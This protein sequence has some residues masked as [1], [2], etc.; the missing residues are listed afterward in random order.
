[1][2]RL[3]ALLALIALSAAVP[4]A[5]EPLL[6]PRADG[7]YSNAL[8]QQ[9]DIAVYLPE[10]SADEPASRYE[11]LYVLDGDWNA[12]IVT[13]IVSFMRQ[14]G[15]LPPLIVVSVPNHFDADGTNSRDHD[16]T[17]TASTDQA[18]S[19][20]AASFLAFLKT[21]LVP[22]VDAHYPANGIRSIH[23]HSYGGLFLFYVLMNDPSLFDGYIVLDPAMG[24]DKHLFDKIV[25]A[26]LPSVPG[27]GKAFYVATR[28]G[29]AYERMGMAGLEPIFRKRAPADFHWKVRG[30]PGETHDSLKLK[31][32]YDA[33]KFVFDG[34]TQDEIDF[35]P[36]G[37]TLIEGR[38]LA[39][40]MHSGGEQLGVRYTTDGSV[41]NASSPQFG[42]SIRIDDAAKTRI[43]LISNRG[44]YDRDLPHHLVDGVALRPSSRSQ[45]P[46]D[47]RW[48]FAMYPLDAWPN[49]G[50]AK[51]LRTD[52]VEHVHD[53]PPPDRD[54]FSASVTRKLV[55][56]EDGY[57]VFY[58]ESSD[59]A[60]LT[61]A[62]K[63]IADVDG[64]AGDREQA[65]VEPLQRGTYTLRLEGR[66]PEKDTAF[67]FEV[68]RDSG[69]A[70]W[71]KHSV[72]RLSKDDR[73]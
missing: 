13:D 31:G 29:P 18:R 10:E 1:M 62:G 68:F 58:V 43:K 14:V 73:R 48:H 2:R 37:G 25:E 36:S 56:D 5:A 44:V 15:F 32:T 57:Y 40:H 19:G 39:L 38:P 17:P 60:C 54:A 34:Y 12:K 70:E 22:Y 11:T 21:E 30:Y 53:L 46:D 6:P 9:R 28:T 66:H 33:L 52:D 47:T 50:R 20:G 69:D 64:D 23:G 67:K 7:L 42:A 3:P 61:V 49:L 55:V 41:P 72:L 4:V 16:L 24:W 51:P 27:K 26:K 8:H 59:K 63:R 71:W 35:V 65:I 45:A